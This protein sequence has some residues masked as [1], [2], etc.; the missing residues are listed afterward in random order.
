[1]AGS[2]Q[3]IINEFSALPSA[4]ARVFIRDVL[5]GLHKLHSIDVI[6]RDVKPQNVLLSL[7]GTCKISDFGTSAWI[8]QLARHEYQGQVTGTP[9]YLAP[10]AARGLSVKESDIWSC[11]IVFV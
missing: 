8:Q 11:G 5:R 9:A 6:H 1:M 4:T 3:R 2:L 7:S 10:E